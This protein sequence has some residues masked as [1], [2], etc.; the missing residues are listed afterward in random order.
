MPIALAHKAAAAAA[1]ELSAN[2]TYFRGASCVP[3]T[4]ASNNLSSTTKI[5]LLTTTTANRPKVFRIK[6][7]TGCFVYLLTYF[8]LLFVG[9]LQKK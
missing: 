6:E 2:L 4:L 7:F 5:L 8:F 9:A 1:A 3:L